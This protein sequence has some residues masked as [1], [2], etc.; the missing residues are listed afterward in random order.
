MHVMTDAYGSMRFSAIVSASLL[1]TLL[2]SGAIPLVVVK[3][4]GLNEDFSMSITLWLYL[5]FSFLCYW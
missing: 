4:K 5:F 2:Y 3:T 1:L